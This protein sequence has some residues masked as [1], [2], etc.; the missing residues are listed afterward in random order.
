ME[1]IF[2][3]RFESTIY[4]LNTEKGHILLL[5]TNN[6]SMFEIGIKFTKSGNL[7]SFHNLE[8]SGGKD[9]NYYGVAINGVDYKQ[10]FKI[11]FRNNYEKTNWWTWDETCYANWK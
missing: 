3:F 10:E 6:D 5:T 1:K 8:G 11:Y 9:L 7:Y 2:D 4:R